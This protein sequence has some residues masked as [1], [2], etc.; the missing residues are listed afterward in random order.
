MS[1]AFNV[2][3][4][5]LNGINDALS[6]IAKITGGFFDKLGLENQKNRIDLFT[7][8]L[9]QV[10]K[11]ID[12]IINKQRKKG[13]G[14]DFDSLTPLLERRKALQDELRI[15]QK[16]VKTREGI[17]DVANKERNIELIT[18]DIN[19]LILQLDFVKEK[20]KEVQAESRKT[21]VVDLDA[22]SPLLE[23]QIGRAHV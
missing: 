13:L 1:V 14:I 18:T 22:I 3:S 6:P 8:Q 23:A 20:I 7:N 15:T 21:G 12:K 10:D 4:I 11:R 9:E 5:I 19:Q 16:L 2:I 17:V